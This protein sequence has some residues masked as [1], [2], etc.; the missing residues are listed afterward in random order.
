[1]SSLAISKLKTLLQEQVLKQAEAGESGSSSAVI[2]AVRKHHPAAIKAAS[3]ELENAAMGRLLSQ[4]AGRKPMDLD[5]AP[6]LFA[7]YPGL[8]Q[9]ITIPVE[10]DNK[11]GPEWKPILTVT[12][13]ELAEWLNDDHK[14]DRTR[15]QRERGMAKLLRDLSDV[16]KGRKDLTVAEVMKLRRARGG[17]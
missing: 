12:L 8:H 5:G 13:G 16:A 11:R 17:K 1:M 4:G 9:S 2:D 14:T 6:D 3:V 7:G 10:R 15:R